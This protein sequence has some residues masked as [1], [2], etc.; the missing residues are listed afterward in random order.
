MYRIQWRKKNISEEWTV[1]LSRYDSRE[2]AQEQINR[3]RVFF[4]NNEYQIIP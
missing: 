1:G 2:K 3:W 4:T